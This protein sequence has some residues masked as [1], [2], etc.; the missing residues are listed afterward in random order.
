MAYQ[1][2]PE[3]KVNENITL[4]RLA[5]DADQAKYDTIVSNREHLLPWLPWAHFY[6]DFEEMPKYTESQIKDFDE[7]IN[8]GYDIFYNGTFVGSIDLHKISEANHS[9]EIGYWLSRDF[10]GK[11]IMTQAANAIIEY[12]FNELKMH[13]ITILAATENKAS[14]AVA[15]R[16]NFEQEGILRD[17]QYLDDKYYDTVVYAKL[18]PNEQ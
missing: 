7:G 8:F 16:H 1:A 15:E 2:K 9:C 11:G 18:N 12:A 17:E 3:I 14:C 5:H 6:H 13:R 4:K 10:T